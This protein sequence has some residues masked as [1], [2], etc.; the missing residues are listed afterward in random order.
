MVRR[1]WVVAVLALLA[2]GVAV[3]G[4][5]AQPADKPIIR[6]GSKNF[7][8]QLL[9]GEMYAL[10]LE[11]HGYRVER[12]LNLA[13]TLVA[14][15]ALVHGEIDLYPEYTGTGLINMLHMEPMSD[16]GQVYEAVRDGYLREWNLVWLDPAPM[17]NTQAIAVT[18]EV[19][20]RYDMYT[21]SRMAE[22]APELV[23]AAVPEFTER[24]DGLKGLQEVYGG[25]QFREVRMVDYGLKYRAL[26]A[27]QA[28]VTV[29]FGTDGEIIGYGFV[30]MEDDKGLWPPYQVA[31]V[32][33]KELLDQ[34][35]EVADIL[36]RLQPHLTGATMQQLNWEVDGNK[37]EYTRV[38]REFLREIGMIH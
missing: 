7:T 18:R 15:Q 14:H 13:G 11:E 9:L 37:R 17:N 23:L 38:A 26:L 31:P 1:V 28:D 16:A 27:G 35:P 8:E 36:N 2:A 19:A 34:A 32:V 33:R 6:I 20:E 21:L 3:A 29:A 12:K 30:V 5:C 22:V 25:F 10:I 24:P 4:A